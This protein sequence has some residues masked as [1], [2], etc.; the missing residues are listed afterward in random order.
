LSRNP[1]ELFSRA[2]EACLEAKHRGR[3]QIVAMQAEAEGSSGPSWLDEW[4]NR[5]TE[6]LQ[7]GHFSLRCQPIVDAASDALAISHYEILLGVHPDGGKRVNIGELMAA[8]EQLGRATEIDKW[9]VGSV[10]DWM[11]RNPGRLENSNGLSINLSAQSINSRNFLDFLSAELDRA[12][13]PGGKLIFEITESA[14]IGSFAHAE[15]F[16]RQIHR[17]GCKF[18]LDDFGVGFSSF[19]YLKNLKVDFLKIDGSFVRNMSQNEIDVALVSSMHETSRFLGIKTV[20]E[21]VENRETLDILRRIGVN[22][23][24]GYHLGKPLPIDESAF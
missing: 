2:D 4:S 11:R 12:D 5:L 10:F 23:V 16:I 9:V 21:M 14:A 22:F 13:I 20:A 15:R 6:W 8:V 19:S 7:G 1:E 24:Q 18:A 17:Y 3:N